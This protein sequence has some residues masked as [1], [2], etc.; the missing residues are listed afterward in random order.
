MPVR[1]LPRPLLSLLASAV[2]FALA[3][4][5]VQA[6]PPSAPGN[7]MA[8]CV[9]ELHR[10]GLY[11]PGA[12]REVAMDLRAE[13]QATITLDSLLRL[14]ALPDVC[15]GVADG[16]VA[17]PARPG[18]FGTL[19]VESALPGIREL[20]PG[21]DGGYATWTPRYDPHA[22]GHDEITFRLFLVDRDEGRLALGEIVLLLHYTP[23]TPDA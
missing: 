5:L 20:A 14:V 10:A 1:F 16:F 13:G 6:N 2:L 18:R 21:P 3:T 8:E 4:P 19:E 12:S 11:G 9:N 17:M 22:E 15:R 7:A 23:P